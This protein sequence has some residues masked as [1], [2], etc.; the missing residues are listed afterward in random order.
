MGTSA[1]GQAY[2]FIEL[3]YKDEFTQTLLE[4]LLHAYKYK[5]LLQMVISAHV[6]VKEVFEVLLSEANDSSQEDINLIL[7]HVR[8]S[9]I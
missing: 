8:A 5:W 1:F 9:W 3:L 7:L 4:K 2:C 6:I